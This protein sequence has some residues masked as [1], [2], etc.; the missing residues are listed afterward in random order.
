MSSHDASDRTV[1]E[2]GSVLEEDHLRLLLATEAAGLGIFEWDLARDEGF[3][4]NRRMHE[5]FGVSAEAGPVDAV[6]SFVLAVHLDDAAIAQQALDEA[7]RSGNFRLQC[8]IR[9]HDDGAVR[10][11]DAWGRTRFDAE[12]RPARLIGV[13]ADVTDAVEGRLRLAASEQRFRALFD[14]LPVGTLVI[15]GDGMIVDANPAALDSLDR[16]GAEVLGHSVGELVIAPQRER[17]LQ[18]VRDTIAEPGQRAFETRL[19]RRD[20]RG[21]DAWV[22]IQRL[23]QQ[24][25]RRV[26]LV[27]LDITEHKEAQAALQ[28]AD[29]LKDEFLAMLGHELRNPLAPMA[30]A[31]AI[32]RQDRRPAA[33][34]ATLPILQRQLQHLTRVTDDLLEIS[35]ITRGRIELK[36]E[37]VDVAAPIQSAIETVRPMVETRGQTLT[38]ERPAAPVWVDVDPVRLAQMLINLL[39]NAAKYTQDGGTITLQVSADAAGVAI[40]VRDNGPGISPELLPRVFDLFAQSERTLARSQG[41]LGIGLALVKRLA[42]LHGGQALAQSE[43]PGRGACF[44]IRLPRSGGPPDAA[45]DDARPGASA[46]AAPLRVLIV[47]DNQDTA[48][49]LA[50]LLRLDGHAVH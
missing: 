21:L 12:G 26:M 10:W 11:I 34:V 38:V 22:T 24:G 13:V 23:E 7:L 35:R 4:Q 44:T 9:R 43:G 3:W 2:T 5:I 50:T 48:D 39:H 20:G 18:A 17:V 33:V 47:D 37:T 14:G 28:L 19:V 45:D 30:N 29:R 41:G 15:R 49:S 27:W 1:R 42:E 36:I 40:S 32:L 6:S 46:A 8:R 25:E 16:A 31:L